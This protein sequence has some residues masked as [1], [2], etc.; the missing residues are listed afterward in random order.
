MLFLLLQDL[1]TMMTE[2]GLEKLTRNEEAEVEEAFN[3][4][5]DLIQWSAEPF[6]F[7]KVDHDSRI[8]RHEFIE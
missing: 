4:M 6:R 1:Q 2:D 3:R 8:C 7:D 5:I